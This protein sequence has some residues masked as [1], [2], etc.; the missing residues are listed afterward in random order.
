MYGEWQVGQLSVAEY[1]S[2]ARR[3][4]RAIRRL[5]PSVKLVSCGLSGWSDWDRVVVDSLASLVDLHSLHIYTGS[6]DYWTNVLSPHQAERAIKYTSA[7]LSEAA[8]NQRLAAAPRI[9]YDEWNVW[10]RTA[11]GTLEERYD[12]SDALAVATYLNIFVRHCDWVAMAN[13]A[14][15][16]NAIAPVVTSPATAGAQPI[17]YPFL[18]HSRAA[19][20]LAV[21]ARTEGPLV[22]A[23]ADGTDRWGH[24]LAD[25]GPFCVLDASA[26]FEPS[27]G[28]LAVTVVNRAEE[29]LAGVEVVVRDATWDGRLVAHVLTAGERKA[30]ELQLDQVHVEEGSE[31]AKGEALSVTLPGRSF[32][33]FEA[34]VEPGG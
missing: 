17:Y 20:E 34:T 33:V 21:D 29:D 13:L 25:L 32:S 10:Y 24:R 27:S 26:T 11:D 31:E 19:L 16:V 6:A 5:D 9:A 22:E 1:V 8:Y 4:A 18:F 30:G 2:E 12:W 3:W 7:A 14:Q 28:R 23:P 15:L